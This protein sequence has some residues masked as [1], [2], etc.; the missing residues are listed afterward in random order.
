MKLVKLSI[1][2]L[3]AYRKDT[4]RAPEGHRKGNKALVKEHSETVCKNTCIP[5]GYRKDTGRVPE[6][7][8][9]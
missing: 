1:R 4:G 2:F 3:P 5:E 7:E 9:K 6:G 8:V